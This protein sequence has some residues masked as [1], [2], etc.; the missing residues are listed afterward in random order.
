MAL[1]TDNINIDE[2]ISAGLGTVSLL[3]IGLWDDRYSALMAI[4]YIS[5]IYGELPAI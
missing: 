3:Y 5:T 1:V 2:L 4:D